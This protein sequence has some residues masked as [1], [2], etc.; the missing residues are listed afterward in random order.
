MDVRPATSRERRRGRLAGRDGRSVGRRARR[1]G[2]HRR[3]EPGAV[4]TAG[5]G[6][7]ASGVLLEYH[8]AEQNSLRDYVTS[9]R[10]AA[11]APFRVAAGLIPGQQAGLAG[12]V[13]GYKPMPA[14]L[15]AITAAQR[16]WLA[17]IAGPQLARCAR[18]DLQPGRY[19]RL[20][21]SDTGTGMDRATLDRV[22]EPFYTTKP[23]GHGTGLGLATVYGIVTQAGGSV[24]IY[25]EPGLGTTVTALL[26]ASGDAVAPENVA[27]APAV[28][29]GHGHGETI[30]LV[31]DEE[32]LRELACRILTRNGYQVCAAT[33]SPD[34]VCRAGDLE[35]TIDMLLTDVVMPEMLGNEVA[36]RVLAMRPDLPVLY[37]SGYAQPFL[38]TRGAL[39]P[40]ID[41]LEKPFTEATLVA[42]VRQALDHRRQT[43]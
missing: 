27:A 35:Q 43:A 14:Q 12:L 23:K 34:A 41:I 11:L 40:P 10:P 28:R 4:A 2:Q 38:G 9:E 36:D 17:K 25:S 7:A 13:R 24:Q 8:T 22:F 16:A 37:M 42:R 3:G 21:V 6:R 20:R 32:D 1:S 29:Y 26:P 18:P 33:T 5:A 19:I 30:L 15:A 39:D 31:E